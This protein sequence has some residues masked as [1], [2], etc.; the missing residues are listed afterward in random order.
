[1]KHWVLLLCMLMPCISESLFAQQTNK[2]KAIFALD[3]GNYKAARE[4]ATRVILKKP[5]DCVGNFI[6]SHVCIKENKLD[7]ALYYI[8][9]A[10]KSKRDYL[11]RNETLATATRAEIYYNMRNYDQ[12]LADINEALKIDR[13]PEYYYFRAA[14]LSNLKKYDMS[15][16]DLQHLVQLKYR[17]DWCYRM[18]GV[19]AIEAKKYPEALAYIGRGSSLKMKSDVKWEPLCMQVYAGLK[20]TANMLKYT[21]IALRQDKVYEEEFVDVYPYIGEQIKNELDSCIAAGKRTKNNLLYRS[22]CHRLAENYDA[23]IDDFY[24]LEKLTKDDS[25]KFYIKYHRANCYYKTGAY[26]DAMI[27]VEDAM[28]FREHPLSYSL[29]A[30]INYSRMNYGASIMDAE[31]AVKMDSYNLNYNFGLMSIYSNL[32]EKDKVKFSLEKLY[33]KYP[34]QRTVVFKLADLNREFGNKEKADSLYQQILKIDTIASDQSYRH[35]ALFYFDRKDEAFKWLDNMSDSVS[36][37]TNSKERQAVFAYNKACF[38]VET[39]DQDK[40]IYYIE[41]ALKLGFVHINAI[42]NDPDLKPLKEN[43]R[44]VEIINKYKAGFDPDKLDRRRNSS[45]LKGDNILLGYT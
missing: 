24:E 21:L 36:R 34:D 14:V 42:E 17:T 30:D 6:M 41:E 9:M 18:L 44:F 28:K 5:K 2:E 20:D 38:Y 19:N 40:A 3:N 32:G 33:E 29:R 10:I 16:G 15:N 11:L 43:A 4:Y 25:D 13:L 39:G 27:D 31:K 12:A 8:D 45:R 22:A 26:A 7:S 37:I 1:M 35:R 23:A